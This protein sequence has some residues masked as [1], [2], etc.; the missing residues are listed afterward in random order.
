MIYLNLKKSVVRSLGKS[1]FI[2]IES[3]RNISKLCYNA[4]VILTVL[5]Y[6][7]MISFFGVLQVSCENA[8][9][10]S[11]VFLSD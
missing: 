4:L 6:L 3:Q 9:R 1:V 2:I 5:V 7:E 8:L 10:S 11:V